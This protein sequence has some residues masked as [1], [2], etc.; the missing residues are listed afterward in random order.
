MR[1]KAEHRKDEW[2][3]SKVRIFGIAPAGVFEVESCHGLGLVLVET[4]G[5]H[6]AIR[7]ELAVPET[8]LK[9]WM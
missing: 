6:E 8:E 1:R 5:T 2:W 7:F 4:L 3:K 9:D